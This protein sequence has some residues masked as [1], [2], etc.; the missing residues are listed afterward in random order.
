MSVTFCIIMYYKFY[1]TFDAFSID[2]LVSER[3]KIWDISCV[4]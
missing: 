1:I 4:G 3:A 2:V